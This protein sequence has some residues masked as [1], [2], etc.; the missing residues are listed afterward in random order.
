MIS[1]DYFPP[2]EMNANH[3][4]L[5]YFAKGLSK[6]HHVTIICPNN[7]SKYESSSYREITI[8]RF[9]Q[10]NI[11]FIGKFIKIFSMPQHVMN[12]IKEQ[13]INNY[14]IFYNSVFA[15]LIS[16][17]FKC[18][19]VYDVMGIKSK[20]LHIDKNLYNF[21]KSFFY[22]YLENILYKNSSIIITINELH[23]KVLSKYFKR[24]IFIIR[25]AVEYNLGIN[26]ALY[27]K[28]KKQ[29]KDYFVLFFVGSLS[30]KRFDRNI[31]ALESL[32]KS[33]KVK[34][35]IA[36]D[37]KYRQYYEK[38][39]QER[40]IN[41]DFVGFVKGKELNSY[42]KMSDICFADVYLEGFPYKIFEYMAMG[43]VS[44]VEQT[45]GVK[46][47]LVDG[48]NS[49]LYKNSKEFEDKVLKLM[50]NIAL[51][52]KIEKNAIMESKKHTWDVRE[53]QF[54]DILKE[55]FNDKKTVQ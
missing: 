43:K 14:F 47:I 16:K 20:E 48:K 11:R 34:I 5:F 25:D 10:I 55:V 22:K 12:L 40:K 7:T 1:S 15:S 52:K 33:Q 54:N 35:V 2:K 37:G 39:F 13:N 36:G 23:K 26:T 44:L 4:R 41:V 28:L 6:H 9:P 32:T 19:K 8:L 27:K 45:E 24:K 46:E 3:N 17:K 50:H 51:K 21:L 42:I 29:Y 30:R 18:F 53:K 38:L 31:D 49:L